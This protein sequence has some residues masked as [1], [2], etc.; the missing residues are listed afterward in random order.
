[1]ANSPGYR[2]A[3]GVHYSPGSRGVQ[4]RCQLGPEQPWRTRTSRDS[5]CSGRPRSP[6]QPCHCLRHHHCHHC[7][8]FLILVTSFNI[9][10]VL[11]VFNIFISL[12]L[13]L[14]LSS[15]SCHPQQT[16]LTSLLL[17]RL[18]AWRT[19]AT[20]CRTSLLDLPSSGELCSVQCA[21]FS[22]L[23]K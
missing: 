6:P 16:P 1:M 5:H 8:N 20:A 14:S 12:P 13:S 7:L 9:L 15:A 21:L 2:G 3:V 11:S 4:Q 17:L 10:I 19:A 23:Y 18:L 22:E